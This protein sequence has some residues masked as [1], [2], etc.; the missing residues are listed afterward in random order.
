MGP[1]S[2][3]GKALRGWGKS[4]S[5]RG[6]GWRPWRDAWL[7]EESQAGDVARSTAGFVLGMALA[8]LYGALVLLA[9]SHNVWYCLVTTVSLGAALGLGMA[10]SVKV[11]VT[12]LLTLPHV[13]TKEGKMLLLLLALGMATQGP[14]TNILHNFSRA[15]ESMS[16]GAE[17]A[18]NQTAERLQ[19][20]REPLLNVLAK[21]KD[22]ARKAKVVG[23]RVRKFFRSIMDSV[24]HVARALRNV[25]IWLVSVGKLCNRELG[26]PYRRCLGIFSEAKD[27][28]ERAIP[29]LYFLCYV[30]VAFKPLCGLANIILLFCVIPQYIQ[31]FLKRQI[32]VPLRNA[33][34]RVR[35]EFE[36]NI[37]AVHH[38]DVSL[39]SSKTLGEVALDIMEGVR[40]CL[41]PAREVLGLFAHFSSCAILYMYL[42][43][44]RYRHRYLQDDTFDNIYITRRFVELDVRRAEQGKPT[45]LPLRARESSRYI[46]PDGLWF[47]QQ[48]RR[49][50]G[51]ELVAVLRHVVLG[52]SLILADYSVFWLLDLVQHQLRGEVVARAPAVLG[53]SVNGTGYTS[54]I[55]RDLVS[56]FEAL[57]QGNIS[58]LSQRCRLQ[59]VEPDYRTYL[60]MGILYGTC[61]FIAVFGSYVGRLRRAVCAAYY[62]CREQERTCFLYNSILV[63]RTGLARALHRA[64]RQRMADGG[65]TNPLL[66]LASKLPVCAR[67]ARLL[68]V[69]QRCCLACGT[70]GEQEC[71]ACITPGCRGLYCGECYRELSNAC[72]ICMAP[73]SQR[74]TG[75]EELDSSDEEA[76]GLWLGALRTL[77]RQP[78][79]PCREQGRLLRQRLQQLLRGSGGGRRLPPALAARLQAGLREEASGESDGGSGEAAGEDSSGSSL[80][81][82]YQEQREGSESELEEVKVVRLPGEEASAR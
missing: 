47:S 44:L 30:I 45:V 8:S 76:A 73:L 23:D 64:A 6:W 16:C 11:R 43:A 59:P 40:A 63:Q 36:F 24:S 71:V 62:P 80:D 12:V 48:E 10:F 33:L 61:L 51:L 79:A 49:R 42:Q 25:W 7:E 39:N 15:A 20:A 34:D 65:H 21:I 46:R 82:G 60:T 27:K 19:R 55:F 35:R 31:S 72:S 81:F 66:I 14:C 3:L 37:S 74:D 5:P 26:T 53:I 67:L 22:I 1:V 75:D 77:R 2:G 68:G 52:L 56:A 41:E 50:Y 29:F 58:V 18:L 28:C 78:Q 54:E 32:A 57:Q 17:L 38:F 69:R 9:Q 4:L 13:F 70:A